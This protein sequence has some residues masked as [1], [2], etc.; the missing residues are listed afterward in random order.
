MTPDSLQATTLNQLMDADN[1]ERLQAVLT[2]L[3]QLFDSFQTEDGSPPVAVCD[4]CAR[5][6]STSPEE[7]NMLLDII[8]LI[9]HLKKDGVVSLDAILRRRNVGSVQHLLN[10]IDEFIGEPSTS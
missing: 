6:L 5:K 9:K 10:L 2:S 4:E 7:Y 1:W 3:Q 8:A